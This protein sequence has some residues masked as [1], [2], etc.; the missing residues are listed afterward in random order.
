MFSDFVSKEILKRLMVGVL[1][2]WGRVGIDS[3]PH[4][5]LPLTVEPTKARL[6]FDLRL[7][8]LCMTN[9]PFSLDR[10]ADV[11]RYVYQGSYMTKCD[12]KSGYD[13]VS[14][15]PSS[16]S[17]VGFQWSGFWFVCTTL[18]F[19]WKISPYI[20]HTIG[21]VASGYLC[22]H[23]IPCSLYID[24]QLNGEL[25][26]S[27]GPWSVLPQNRSQEYSFNAAI[28]AIY[29]VLSLLVDLGYTIGIAKSVL[30]LIASV[31]Y[32]GLTVDI[33]KQAFIVSW[34]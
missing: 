17:H 34:W 25:V 29:C 32:L 22:A 7:L 14:L 31:E 26:T 15:L 6:C 8:N 10:L 1:I 28:A 19:G 2:V 4:L 3:K 24:H 27:Q 12:D 30:Y 18:P 23:G 16:Q 9:V 11:P 20:Y 5:V 21:L 33:L 13:H